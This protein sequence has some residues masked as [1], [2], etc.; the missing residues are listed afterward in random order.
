M[1]R[2]K[3]LLEWKGKTLLDHVIGAA[4]G[5]GFASPILVLGPHADEILAR[6]KLSEKCRVVQNPNHHDGQAT[7]LAAGIG[8][9]TG[10]CEAVICL[11]GDQPL[12]SSVLLHRLISSYISQKPDILYP[13]CGGVRGNPVVIGHSLFTRLQTAK[14]D[15]GA[16]RF[17]TDPQLDICP[18][19]LSDPAVLLDLDTMEEYRKFIHNHS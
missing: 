14:G 10:R 16:R 12:V 5:G 1:G 8:E 9:V 6:V 11:L 7:S 3:Q 13:T 15:T 19:E 2:P 4:L 17:L 18:V